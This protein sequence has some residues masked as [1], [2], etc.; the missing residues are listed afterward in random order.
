MAKYHYRGPGLDLFSAQSGGSLKGRPLYV[1]DKSFGLLNP[2][3]SKSYYFGKDLAWDAEAGQFTEG[4]VTAIYHFDQ[5]GDYVDSIDGLSLALPTFQQLLTRTGPDAKRAL[6][7]A[8]MWGN[9]TLYGSSGNDRLAGGHGY[10]TMFGFSGDDRL[11]GGKGADFLVGGEGVDTL[12][13]GRGDDTI[14]GGTGRDLIKG[15]GGNDLIYG[16]PDPDIII[17]DFDWDEMTVTYDGEDYSFWVETPDGCKD[18]VFSALTFACDT[19]TYF[20]DLSTLSFVLVSDNT[21]SDWL[22]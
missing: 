16:G 17:Y 12:F 8:I 4:T 13:G 9:D 21:G 18:H 5:S 1:D 20:F 7:E 10:D 6:V 2:D 22:T 11:S 3:G 19:G 15:G 14:D